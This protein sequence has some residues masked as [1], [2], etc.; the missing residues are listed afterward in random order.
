MWVHEHEIK[1]IKTL[2]EEH[3]ILRFSHYG[4][5]RVRGNSPEFDYVIRFFDD[6]TAI[7]AKLIIGT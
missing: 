7:M 1:N 2:L 4:I 5:H 6:E 3:D